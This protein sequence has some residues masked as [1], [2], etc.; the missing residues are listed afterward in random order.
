MLKTGRIEEN[1]FLKQQ[2]PQPVVG[3]TGFLKG[4]KA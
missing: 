1:V 3:Y 2:K 4:V